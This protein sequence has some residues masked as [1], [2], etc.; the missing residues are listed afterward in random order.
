LHLSELSIQD[1]IYRSQKSYEGFYLSDL[2]NQTKQSEK[3]THF[4]FT[5]ADGFV[6]PMIPI[7]EVSLQGFL[8]V[9]DISSKD[10]ADD[11]QD[12]YGFPDRPDG[13]PRAGTPA[14][15]YL[16]WPP[17]HPHYQ[18]LDQWPYQ[19]VSIELVDMGNP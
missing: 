10:G 5:C 16:V 1:P 14:P 19:V 15:S 11:T 12:W 6:P 4:R 18:N 7:D 2:L 8:A 17:G 13:R 9:R 3:F